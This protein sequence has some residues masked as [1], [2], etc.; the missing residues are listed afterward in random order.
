VSRPRV[1]RDA[2]EHRERVDDEKWCE[3]REVWSF[4]AI[5]VEGGVDE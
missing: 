1:W 3:D 5:F 2:F 4:L